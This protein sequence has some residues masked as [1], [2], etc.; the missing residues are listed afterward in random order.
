[1]NVTILNTSNVFDYSVFPLCEFHLF[2]PKVLFCIIL[3]EPNY[4]ITE[5]LNN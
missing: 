4:F 1:M 2:I 3:K 5:T